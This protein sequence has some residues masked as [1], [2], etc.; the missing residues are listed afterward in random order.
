[1]ALSRERMIFGAG[2]VGLPVQNGDRAQGDRQQGDKDHEL[3][4]SQCFLHKAII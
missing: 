2:K 1:L 3:F 4:C